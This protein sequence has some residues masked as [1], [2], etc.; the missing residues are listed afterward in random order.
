M[1]RFHIGW[2]SL[3]LLSATTGAILTY[4]LPAGGSPETWPLAIDSATGTHHFAVE[5]ALTPEA[6]AQ[7]LMFRESLPDDA[8]MLFVYDRPDVRTMWMKNTSLSLDMLFIDPDGIVRRII[9]DTIPL[10][11]SMLIGPRNILYVLELRA[12]ITRKLGIK[13]GDRIRNL[14]AADQSSA[15]SSR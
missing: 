8:G 1:K 9:R 7:G 14:P 2:I 15:S 11:S 3:L 10:S 5:L 4:W 6:Q 12:G 13:A